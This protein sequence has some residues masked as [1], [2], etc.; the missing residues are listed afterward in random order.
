MMM[1]ACS[2]DAS[3]TEEAGIAKA[4][5]SGPEAPFAL[6]TG[7]GDTSGN[8]TVSEAGLEVG[9]ATPWQWASVTKQ[10]VAVLV[11]QD[12]EAGRLAL[13]DTI[14]DHLPDFGTGKRGQITI[15]Q[16]LRNTSGLGEPRGLPER[17]ATD[18][19]A[20]CDVP[21][22]G[23][24]GA[25]FRYTNCDFIVAAAIL[26]ETNGKAWQ[27]LLQSR[28]LEPAGMMATGVLAAPVTDGSV[29]TSGGPHLFGAAGAMYGPPEDLLKFNAALMDGTLLSDASLDALW[30]GDPSKGYV[31]LGAWEFSA[32]LDG[33]DGAVRLVERRGYVGDVQVRNLI[34]PELET[35][36]VAFT[37]E[38]G[39]DFG[40]IWRGSGVTYDLAS[41][42]FC[43]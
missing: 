30:D 36:L 15:E 37:R 35:S 26:E 28:I 18:P 41:R 43:N 33:C 9:A 11:M 16:L 21:P 8:Y 39:A 27:D 25:A 1:A 10:F 22:V 7:T 32:P 34:A 6:V 13:D 40:E 31:A 5:R 23:K 17:V 42:A 20:F 14:A 3:P 38:K 12:V 19:L 29:I 24:P 2:G 4:G